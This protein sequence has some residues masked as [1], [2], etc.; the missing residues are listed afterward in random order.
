MAIKFSNTITAANQPPIECQTPSYRV[1]KAIE[2]LEKA[3]NKAELDRAWTRTGPL[4]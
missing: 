4:A 1:S 3:T 2:A